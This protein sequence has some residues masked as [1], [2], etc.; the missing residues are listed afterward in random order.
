MKETFI[1]RLDI[2]FLTF[3]ILTFLDL[4]IIISLNLP[5]RLA[6]MPMM[7]QLTGADL[8]KQY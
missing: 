8:E 4:N 2:L 7:V 5:T 3:F 1:H 6:R